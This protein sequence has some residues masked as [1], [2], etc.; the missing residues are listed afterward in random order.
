MSHYLL[1]DSVYINNQPD[2]QMV[3]KSEK[4]SIPLNSIGCYK[5]KVRK[6]KG[7]EDGSVSKMLAL[8][9]QGPE[10]GSPGSTHYGHGRQ[11]HC[12]LLC[13]ML[14]FGLLSHCQHFQDTTLL[15]HSQDLRPSQ[16]LPTTLH[17]LCFPVSFV[18]LENPPQPEDL[19]HPTVHQA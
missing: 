6:N 3:E 5:G 10:F 7:W 2:F 13:L 11:Q 16:P 17:I 1:S 8:Q 4:I 19:G 14:A 18:S 15:T 9:A 12:H